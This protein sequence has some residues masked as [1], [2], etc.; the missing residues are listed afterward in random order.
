MKNIKRYIIYFIAGNLIIL[1]ID[2]FTRLMP[3]AC[4]LMEDASDNMLYAV[5]VI[6]VVLGI[7]L[8]LGKFQKAILIAI[9]I[10]MLWAIVMHLMS[11]TYDIG[12]AIF[13]AIVSAIPLFLKDQS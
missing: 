3:L 6:E 11:G 13:L 1:G 8:L 2:K 12:A 5:G 4:T 7:L 10:F 9:V